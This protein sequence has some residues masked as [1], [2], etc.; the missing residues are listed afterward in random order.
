[1]FGGSGLSI[2]TSTSTE[3][4]SENQP[5]ANVDANIAR[6]RRKIEKKQLHETKFSNDNKK[7]HQDQDQKEEIREP[8]SPF[9]QYSTYR[10]Q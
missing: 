3:E 10:Q 2:P 9:L 4:S 1:M 5:S 6:L 7:R 8:M